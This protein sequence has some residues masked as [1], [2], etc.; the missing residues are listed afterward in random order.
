ML[1]FPYVSALVL[2]ALLCLPDGAAAQGVPNFTI[3]VPVRPPGVGADGVPNTNDDLLPITKMEVRIT[4]NTTGNVA[5]NITNPH[6]ET[7]RFPAA[8]TMTIGSPAVNR[9]F[10]VP[11]GATVGDTVVVTPPSAGLA[12]DDPA[13][14]IYTISIATNSDYNTSTCAS[15]IAAPENWQIAIEGGTNRISGVCVFAFDKAFPGSQCLLNHPILAS[16]GGPLPTVGGFPAGS[17][18]QQ[19]ATARPAVDA[20]LVLDRSG[21][22]SS[23]ALGTNPRTK[24]EALRAA[25]V[26]FVNVWAGLRA[27]E[28]SPPADRIGLVFFDTAVLWASQMGIAAWNGFTQGVDAL[29]TVRDAIVNNMSQVQTANM[30]AMGGGLV[31]AD[32]KFGAGSGSNRKVVLLMSNGMQNQNPMVGVNSPVT[33]TQVNTF[34]SATPNAT[35]PLPNQANYQLYSVTVGTSTAVSAAINMNLAKARGGFYVNSEDNPELV[36]PFF[37]ELLQNFLHF[38]S[39]EIAR[40]V[41]GNVTATPLTTTFAVP[42]SAR[43]AA[44]ILQFPPGRAILRLR[45]TPPGG[46]AREQISRAGFAAIRIDLPITPMPDPKADWQIEVAA[47]QGADVTSTP[48]DVI[49][50]SD[51]LAIDSE[52]TTGGQDLV[53]G[54]QVQLRAKITE[55]G[56]PI[57]NIGGAAGGRAVVQLIRPGTS[58]GDLLSDNAAGATQPTNDPGTAADA[59]LNTLM[60][61]SPQLLQRVADTLTM[62]DNGNAANGDETANDGIYSAVFVPQEPGHYNFLFGVEGVGSIARFSRQQL[63]TVHVRSEPS[64]ANTQF[65]TVIQDNQLVITA[66]PRTFS[67]SKMGPGFANYLWFTAPGITPVKPVDNLDGTYRATLPT[68]TGPVSMHFL[69]VAMPIADEVTPSQLPGGGLGSGT[70]VVQEVPGAGG[71]GGGLTRWWWLLILLI[72]LLLALY[73]YRRSHP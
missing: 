20:I 24:I 46:Q 55:F 50:V 9:S 2:G 3:T 23:Q 65:G 32:S 56:L 67:G 62:V 73:L 43:T 68:T 59:K 54:Q 37:L 66:T 15:L 13:R 36:R 53:P 14:F 34:N 26:D 64:A 29:D 44:V 42:T 70:V 19:C 33:P 57:T 58:I 30:T 51:D 22:M 28:A 47:P 10:A 4:V 21:S 71:G 61:Q 35:T 11:A 45:V 17:S 5:F 7:L 6:A 52:M 48:V 41:S 12:A 49:V 38:N 31:A 69:D 8:G 39:Y 63:K 60:Q 27:T 1:R 18:V 72:V 16:G 40:M 25:V